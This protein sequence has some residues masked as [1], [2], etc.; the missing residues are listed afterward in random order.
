M[1]KRKVKAKLKKVKKRKNPELELEA[2]NISKELD[3]NVD[4]KYISEGFFAETFYFKLLKNKLIRNIILKPDEYILKIFKN[5]LEKY[6]AAKPNNYELNRL[7]LLSK[8]GL[9]PKI[10]IIDKNFII[11]KYIKGITLKEY[12]QNIE[13]YSLTEKILFKIEYII[14][15]WH[16]LGFVHGDLYDK[17]IL[18]TNTDKIYFIDPMMNKSIRDDANE[19]RILYKRYLPW[20][21]PKLFYD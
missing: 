2:E 19:I 17:N 14:E 10:Y 18:I 15:K 11:M 20:K 12:L 5:D 21:K 1:I 16:D 13:N 3:L 6:N 9:I 4:F 8:Y 7:K